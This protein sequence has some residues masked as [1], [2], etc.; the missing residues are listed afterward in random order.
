MVQA[1]S[2]V[3]VESRQQS[4]AWRRVVAG[5]DEP[6]ADQRAGE[7]GGRLAG[8][9]GPGR[10]A[11]EADHVADPTDREQRFVDS[12]YGG[13]P[14][15]SQLGHRGFKEARL[16][17]S[18]EEGVGSHGPGCRGTQDLFMALVPF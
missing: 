3:P 16:E 12:V 10:A 14:R 11:V 2:L 17:D 13:L 15:R 9:F 6:R 8:V 5:L 7:R 4:S 1:G 18:A